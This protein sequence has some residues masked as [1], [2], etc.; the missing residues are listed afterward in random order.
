[1]L[2]AKDIN[3]YVQ[4]TCFLQVRTINRHTQPTACLIHHYCSY[5]VVIPFS[6]EI[7]FHL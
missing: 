4:F 5:L 1:M 2:I 7:I 6:K 3:L